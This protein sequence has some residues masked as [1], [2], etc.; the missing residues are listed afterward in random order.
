MG[1]SGRAPTPLLGRWQGRQLNEHAMPQK[2]Q[3]NAMI[4]IDIEKNSFMS[5]AMKARYRA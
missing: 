3:H 5:Q 1:W 4:G 2:L